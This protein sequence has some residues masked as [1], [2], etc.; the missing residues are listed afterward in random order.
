MDRRAGERIIDSERRFEAIV[1]ALRD[2]VTIRN[3]D[4]E[5]IYANRAALVHL[6]LES[7]EELRTTSPD[8]IMAAHRVFD[9]AGHELSM[10][11]VP[12]VRILRGE[13]MEPEPLVIRDVNRETGVERWSLLKA[14]PIVDES[15]QVEA[16]IM[17]TEDVT[18]QKRAE[19]RAAFLASANEVLSSSLDYEQTL[20]NVA[21]LAV[22]QIA[23]WC[24]VDLMD[25]S[26]DRKPVAVAHVDP[27]RLALAEELRRYE[28]Q[29]LN[30]EQG[31]GRVFRT[32]EPM[33][34]PEVTDEMLKSSAVDERH[35]ELLR[36]VEMRSALVVPMKLGARTLGAMTLVMAE[37]GRRLDRSDVDLASQAAARAAVAIENARLYSERTRIAQ[38]LARSLVPEQLEQVPGYELA[39]AYLPA[40]EGSEVSGDFYD[41][42]QVDD[43]WFVT[44]GDVTG[45]G[46]EAA[47]LTGFVRYTMRAV[48]EFLSS[49][50]EILARL[51]AAL[52]KQ[53]ELSPCTALCLRLEQD[54]TLLAVGG[55]PLPLHIT[56]AGVRQL[57]EY[58][59]LLGAI[60]DAT[61]RDSA[62]TLEPGATLVIYTDGVTDAVGPGGERWGLARLRRTLEACSGLSSAAVV[63]RVITALEA[64]Q[65]GP[66]A[67]DAATLAIRPLPGASE[68]GVEQTSTQ[69]AAAAT[70]V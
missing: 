5:L 15:G 17:V 54:R 57:G 10:D 18:A 49:P 3:R 19:Q 60:A 52:K 13:T 56:E 23:D 42:W 55:H 25:D 64:F 59:P 7:I 29:E 34:Y 37:S 22:P 30:P 36:A 41:A 6:G 45:K 61:W 47:A 46:V 14:A 44:I 24:A 12:S 11:Q 50:A 20:R 63:D 35:L 16:T 53:R 38:T 4:D 27:A 58:G 51:D 8:T 48:S 39:S 26:G 66:H 1:G 67:D 32:G 31:L 70:A 21:E 69:R 40:G 33:L 68:T 2:P 65:V 28:P 9:E 62:V 43:A